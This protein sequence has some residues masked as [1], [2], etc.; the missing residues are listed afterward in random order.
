M[1]WK[2]CHL[3]CRVQICTCTVN[4]NFQ[5]PEVELT[6]DGLKF[7]TEGLGVRGRNKYKIDVQ[8]YHEVDPEV[9]LSVRL[10]V[11]TSLMYSS[12]MRWIQR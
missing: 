7:S 5:S 9:S 10:S 3:K 12:T 1:K 11:C 4:L 6:E 2:W 8:F